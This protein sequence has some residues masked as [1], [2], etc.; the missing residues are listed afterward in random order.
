MTY[1]EVL[2]NA[3]KVMMPKCRVCPECNGIAC[4]GEVPGVGAIGS[5]SAFTE[6]RTYL[7]QI[8]IHMDAV[9]EDYEVDASIELFGKNFAYPFFV[10]PIGGMPFNYTGH[11]T[12]SEYCEM[13]VMG[14]VEEGIFAFTGDGPLDDYFPSTLPSIKAANGVAVST[15]KPWDRQKVL[16]RIADLEQAGCMA[17]AMDI[18][19]AALVNLKLK[20]K[21]AYTKSVSELQEFVAAT[22]M[23]FI[24]KGIMTP[25]SAKKCKEAGAYGIVVSNHGGRIMEDFPAPCSMLAEIRKAVG[26]GMKIFVDGGI[27]SGADVFKC[28]ALGADAVL[29]G[30]PYAIAA[31]GG[32]KEGVKIYTRKIAQELQEIMR[33]ADCHTLKDITADKIRLPHWA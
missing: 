16:G 25:H 21:P 3:R 6:C 12:E 28:L 10:A 7:K 18:D 19:S 2:E 30:R 31:H 33:M 4:R 22:K 24:V 17:F 15:V 13:T 26:N 11:L 14:A 1:Q 32:G 9:H 23:P 29:I 8:K 20:G 5:A 27:R